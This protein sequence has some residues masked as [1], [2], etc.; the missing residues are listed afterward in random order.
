MEKS[1]NFKIKQICLIVVFFIFAMV[2]STVFC[3]EANAAAPTLMQR[4]QAQE[5]N[6]VKQFY[7]IG[8]DQTADR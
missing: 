3:V 2:L 4:E 8:A 5:V 7:V 6:G 1:N